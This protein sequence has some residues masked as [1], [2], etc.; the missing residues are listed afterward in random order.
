[1]VEP[2][3]EQAL[4]APDHTV[5]LLMTDDEIRRM[6]R[7]AESLALSGVWKDIR[8]A[9]A[10]FAKMV[11]GRD[12][13]MT[14][15]Q[16]MQGIHFVE[17]NIQM[18]YTTLGQFIRSRDG[19]DYRAGWIKEMPRLMITDVDSGE[20]RPSDVPPETV[21]VWHDEEDPLDGRDVVGAV[22]V[23]SVDGAQRGLSRYTV[24]DATAAGLIKP[25]LDKRAAW[26]TSRRNMLLARA[27][28]NGVKWFVP[29]VMGGLPAY[30]DGEIGSGA[31]P[32]LTAGSTPDQADEGS[33]VE[34][35]PQVEKVLARAAEVGH[36]G[37]ANRA[38]VELAVG[39]RAP[40]VVKDW[41][42]RAHAELDRVVA[43][44]QQPE[45]VEAVDGVVE[46]AD[47]PTGPNAPVSPNPDQIVSAGER[48]AQIQLLRQRLR[49]LETTDQ[50]G[51]SEEDA[52]QLREEVELVE[53]KLRAL[54]AEA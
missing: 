22:I 1:M 7:I 2:T 53:D 18:H 16:A 12:L 48:E 17:G 50:H 32:S 25:G 8:K 19:Y 29:E 34:L 45:A 24:E 38:A 35:G 39:N 49:G 28:S 47:V 41:A 54:G 40:G 44:R 26:M 21:F 37:L 30:V 42:T 23:F 36:R 10:A 20:V 51:L 9:E 13:G 5:A 46:V 27:M 11:I 31:K 33:G 14:P 52:E 6:Y 43:D 4:V 15:A 3:A